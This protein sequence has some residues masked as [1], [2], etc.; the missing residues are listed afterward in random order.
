MIYHHPCPRPRTHA[1]AHISTLP[2]T[3]VPCQADISPPA[4]RQHG[5]NIASLRASEKHGVLISKWWVA[6]RVARRNNKLSSATCPEAHR[7]KTLFPFARLFKNK[8]RRARKM[9]QF[10]WYVPMSS[11]R[12]FSEHSW[13]GRLL[14]LWKC[15][16]P[17]ARAMLRIRKGGNLYHP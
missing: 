2:A 13:H 1:R 10:R 4:R 12:H 8:R 3:C 6:V 7:E 15:G 11:P 5:E 9:R 17:S 16:A 14:S